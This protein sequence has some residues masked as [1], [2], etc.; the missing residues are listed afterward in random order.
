MKWFCIMMNIC[1]V[2]LL[3]GCSSVSEDP[4]LNHYQNFKSALNFEETVKHF[5][6]LLKDQPTIT[7]MTRTGGCFE[8]ESKSTNIWQFICGHNPGFA[9]PSNPRN[10]MFSIHK[11]VIVKKTPK[12]EVIIG[13]TPAPNLLFGEYTPSNREILAV[14]GIKAEFIGYE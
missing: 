12:S 13:M 9:G 2:L 1:G 7:N 4:R 5:R 10:A 8:R 3:V 14:A 11:R 6:N